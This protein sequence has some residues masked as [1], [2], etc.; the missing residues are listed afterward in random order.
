MIALKFEYFSCFFDYIRKAINFIEL[1][2][3]FSLRLLN[4][5]SVDFIRVPFPC[6]TI[7][8]REEFYYLNIIVDAGA[9]VGVFTMTLYTPK[10]SQKSDRQHR[11]YQMPTPLSSSIFCHNKIE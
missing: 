1:I 4:L 5:R 3:S 9:L 2:K 7:A 6:F 10:I 11:P 8:Q